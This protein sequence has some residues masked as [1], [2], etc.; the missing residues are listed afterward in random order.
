[1]LDVRALRKRHER[2][3]ADRSTHDTV[4]QDIASLMYPDQ[5]DFLGRGAQGNR[6]NLRMFD[7][8]AFQALRNF[9]AGMYGMMTNPA[10]KWFVLEPED[11][12]LMRFD[13]VKR[14]MADMTRITYASYGPAVS[15]FYS[16]MEPYFKQIGAFGNAVQFSVTHPTEKRFLD[17]TLPLSQCHWYEN[18]LGEVD[19]MFQARPMTVRQ[20]AQ[21]FGNK[22]PDALQSKLQS[23]PDDMTD[24]ARVVMPNRE[25]EAGSF[26]FR[27]FR[28]ASVTYHCAEGGAPVQVRGFRE[29]P[30]FV[31]RWSRRSGDQYGQGPGHVALPDTR[32]LNQMRLD[33]LEAAAWNARPAIMAADETWFDSIEVAPAKIIYGALDDRGNPRL[34]TLSAGGN[35]AIADE[36]YQQLRA[37]V[38]EYFFFSLMQVIS[39][40]GM[41]ATEV[42]ERSEERLRLMGPNVGNV[43]SQGLSASLARRVAMLD[44]AGAFPPPP[45]RLASAPLKVRY[46]SP[47][48]KAQRSAEGASAIRVVQNLLDYARQSGDNRPLHKINSSAY[49]DILGESFGAPAD[50]IRG[51][52]EA[53][54]LADAEA[55][56]QAQQQA[57]AVAK[58]G[59]DAIAKI[60]SA[61]RPTAR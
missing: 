37:V 5:A 20:A 58:D 6:R 14:Y 57:V 44:R 60:G 41:T 4:F 27:G 21:E 3:K 35:L 11:D 25:Y 16:E 53:D 2:A 24:F 38:Q 51:D 45:D 10:T 30:Y 47:M 23:S 43:E 48:A 15:S 61:V 34:S 55:E 32:T 52:E 49:A 13:D 54:A 42:L 59:A 29:F 39:R 9:A 40:T 1:M 7:G 26:G 56:A 33:K 8:T 19:T 12:G 18:D 36:E 50:L 22:L 28:F 17:R 31:T 46:I